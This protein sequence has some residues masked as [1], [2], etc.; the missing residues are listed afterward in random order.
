MPKLD[1]I[2][3]KTVLNAHAQWHKC[4]LKKAE[5]GIPAGTPCDACIEQARWE[6]E[7]LFNSE[8]FKE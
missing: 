6:T 1:P 8:L 5:R 4:R 7:Q 3:L 2:T